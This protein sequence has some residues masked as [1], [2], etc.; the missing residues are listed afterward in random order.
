MDVAGY[1]LAICQVMVC[2][3][4]GDAA[5]TSAAITAPPRHRRVRW[6]IRRISGGSAGEEVHPRGGHD[7]LAPLIP[8]LH[9][10]ADDPPV[11]FAARGGRLGHGETGGERVA[12]AHRLEPAQLVDARGAKARRVLEEAV[13]EE[14]HE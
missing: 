9:H 3:A 11:R 5:K 8:H 10:R 12:R 1:S 4:A 6:A 7:H 13:V 2:A 14:A